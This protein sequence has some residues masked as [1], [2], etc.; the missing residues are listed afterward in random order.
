MRSI[1][2][3]KSTLKLSTIKPSLIIRVDLEEEVEILALVE[4]E[5]TKEELKA[6]HHQKHKVY[7]NHIKFKK[8]NFITTMF[9]F[10]AEA[11][12]R[13]PYWAEQYCKK[14]E[15]SSIESAYPTIIL[16]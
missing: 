5:E 16:D 1:M 3:K 4:E 15:S 14:G 9:R 12:I 10:I 13:Q 8:S 2:K 7:C 6:T 11:I